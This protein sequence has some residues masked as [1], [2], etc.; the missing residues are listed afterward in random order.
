[1]LHN[2]SVQTNSQYIEI[3]IFVIFINLRKKLIKL[4][5]RYISSIIYIYIDQAIW[6]VGVTHQGTNFHIVFLKGILYDFRKSD[7]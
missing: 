2:G 1:M 6:A 3:F 7:G 4:C 5:Q